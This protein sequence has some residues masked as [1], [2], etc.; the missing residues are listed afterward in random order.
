VREGAGSVSVRTALEH[1]KRQVSLGTRYLTPQ[2]H[3]VFPTFVFI[4]LQVFCELSMPAYTARIVDVGIQQGGI[5]SPA[6]EAL[7]VP[8]F[9]SLALLMNRQGA[10]DAMQAYELVSPSSPNAAAYIKKFPALAQ[11]PLMIRKAKAENVPIQTAKAFAYAMHIRASLEGEKSDLAYKAVSSAVDA[12]SPEERS[13]LR[14][15]RPAFLRQDGGAFAANAAKG[16]DLFEES[17]VLKSAAPYARKELEGAGADADARQ[18]SYLLWAGGWL[19]GLSL[20]AMASSIATSFFAARVASRFGRDMR[21][22]LH[23]KALSLSAVEV[24]HFT[25]ASLITRTTTDVQQIQLAT[26]TALRVLITAPLLGFGALAYAI[27]IGFSLTWIIVGFAAFI[28]FL[29]LSAFILATPM[30]FR[31]QGFLDQLNRVVRETLKGTF[32]IRAFRSEKREE[33]RIAEAAEGIRNSRVFLIRTM[34]VLEP[35]ILLCLNLATALIVW[36]GASSVGQG[37]MQ[38]GGL[39]AFITYATQIVTALQL[40][41]SL[42]MSFARA[43]ISMVRVDEVLRFQPSMADPENPQ[44]F[45]QSKMGEVEFSDVS[46]SYAGSG[47]KALDGISFTAEPGQ[48]T[49]II[50]ATGSGKSAIA[51]LIPRLR[52]VSGGSVRVCGRDVREVSRQSLRGRIGYVPQSAAL[53]SGTIESNI[54]FAN[55]EM[56]DGAMKE[57]AALSQSAGFIEAK[58]GSYASRV[59]QSGANISGGQ[60]QRLAIARALAKDPDIIVLDDALSNLD[61]RTDAALRKALRENR[62]GAT[63]I[64]I[65]QRVFTI[66][67]AD[68]IVVLEEGRVAGCGTHDELMKNCRE[69]QLIASS[70]L[71]E[72]NL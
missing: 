61:F 12:L 30:F 53:F 71:E 50:G 8:S 39:L 17:L 35:A 69:Y 38:V 66:R 46:F 55:P 20:A 34:G 68:K 45:S 19:I 54:K 67:D 11:R 70:Q 72:G 40:V 48:V 51:S 56:G 47:A 49:A 18:I 10:A 1:M 37:S 23:K 42:A 25:A 16:L 22:D 31:V 9:E 33:A 7:S 24:D 15:D 57:A 64:L 6:P 28:V 13:L 62:P 58:A 59:S 63:L 41:A 5:A 27:A 32:V 2:W 14:L 43:L 36:F 44:E 4:C 60:R 29:I 3:N 26:T 52:E 65:A 21:R